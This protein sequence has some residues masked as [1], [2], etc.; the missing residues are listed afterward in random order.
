VYE[1]GMFSGTCTELYVLSSPFLPPNL[2][3]TQIDPKESLDICFSLPYYSCMHLIQN[4]LPLLRKSPR[5]RVLSVLNA[6]WERKMIDEDIGS[7]PVNYGVAAAVPHI[8]TLMTLGLEYSAENNKGITFIHTFP[9]LCQPR[10]ILGWKYRRG[11]GWW[12]R[13]LWCC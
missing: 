12:G 10:F 7:D 8:T 3:L 13:R 6:G 9:G 11:V 1:P 2:P 5:S 4:P